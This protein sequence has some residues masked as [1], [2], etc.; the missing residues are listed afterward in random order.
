M[1]TKTKNIL[2]LNTMYINEYGTHFYNFDDVKNLNYVIDIT[3]ET[4]AGTVEVLTNA[5]GKYETLVIVTNEKYIH[6]TKSGF[7]IDLPYSICEIGMNFLSGKFY[8]T[9][10]K[11][12]NRANTFNTKEDAIT[13]AKQIMFLQTYCE[14]NKINF[15]VI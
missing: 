2:G 8:V 4:V 1:E 5:Y 13:F 14:K 15:Q 3:I 7:S 12:Q 11:L 10:S 6:T 9:N